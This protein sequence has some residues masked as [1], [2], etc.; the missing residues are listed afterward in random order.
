MELNEFMSLLNPKIKT[1]VIIY[2]FRDIILS[3]PLFDGIVDAVMQHLQLIT[4][5]PD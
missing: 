4:Y 3:V 1:Q 2:E 5:N